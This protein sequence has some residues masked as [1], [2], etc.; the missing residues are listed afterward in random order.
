MLNTQ[1]FKFYKCFI[2]THSYNLNTILLSYF[3]SKMIPVPKIKIAEKIKK[4]E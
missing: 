3:F 4:N 1:V 2:C